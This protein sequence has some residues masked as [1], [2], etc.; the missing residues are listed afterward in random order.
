MENK[1]D[2]ARPAASPPPKSREAL[3][4]LYWGLGLLAVYLAIA[5]VAAPMVWRDKTRHH[6]L[7]T[8]PRITQTVNGIPGDPVNVAL[9]GTEADVIHA[10]IKAHWYPADAITLRSSVRIAV[11]SVFR[12]P[13][14]DAPVS[15]LELFG[16]K[17]DLAFEQP[18]GDSPRQ[19]HH[20]RFWH[21][22][23]LHE[24]REVWFGAATFDE[25]VGLS[26][27]T[28]QVTHHIGPDI[29]A[30]RDRILS[31]LKAG[32]LT[33][34]EYYVDDFHPEQHGK[35]GGGDPWQTDGRLGVAVLVVNTNVPAAVP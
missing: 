11:D 30:E 4:M 3:R 8:G 14:D 22:D 28:G 24:G 13:D 20:V 34:K 1:P 32:H 25:R 5:Y 10:M 2:D 16:R 29:D 19:R 7:L 26:H 35:N 33:V 6:E 15:T 27:T 18:V 21:W 9:L 23:K 31:E 12:R 17:Q